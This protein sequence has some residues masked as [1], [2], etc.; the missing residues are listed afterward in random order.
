MPQENE[1]DQPAIAT[2]SPLRSKDAEDQYRDLI[3]NI[4]SIL[5]ER[6]LIERDVILPKKE[7]LEV[8][9]ADY[10]NAYPIRLHPPCWVDDGEHLAGVHPKSSLPFFINP[11]GSIICRLCTGKKSFEGILKELKRI[12]FSVDYDVLLRDGLSFLMLLEEMN[13]IEFKRRKIE[14]IA[15]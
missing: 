9:Y 13:L 14:S 2:F 15:R 5:N 10:A 4:G 11:T 8:H 7:K 12:W 1:Y 6:K 3:N